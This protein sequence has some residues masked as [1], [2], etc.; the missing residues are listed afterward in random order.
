MAEKP[1]LQNLRYRFNKFIK[2]G[3]FPK[4]KELSKYS[5][6]LHGVNLD[7]EYHAKLASKEDPRNPF[8]LGRVSGYKK[9][10]YG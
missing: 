4:A 3:N 8:N 6:V 10:K 5:Q 7:E 9:Q 1:K 2:E